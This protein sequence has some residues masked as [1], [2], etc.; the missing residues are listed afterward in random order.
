MA[1]HVCNLYH[2]QKRSIEKWQRHYGSR[3]LQQHYLLDHASFGFVGIGLVESD[4]A[5]R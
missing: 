3:I 2:V 4:R 5:W 1:W